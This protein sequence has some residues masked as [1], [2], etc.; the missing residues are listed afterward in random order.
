MPTRPT[1]APR[2]QTL[3]VVVILL[4]VLTALALGMVK[5]SS[6]ESD[7]VAAKRRHDKAVNC[8]DGA[9]EMLLSQFSV[10]G[11]SPTQVVLNRQVDDQVYASGHYDNFAVTSVVAVSGTQTGLAGVTDIS[12]RT[13]GS[14]PGGQVYRMTVICGSSD[15]ADGGTRESEVEFLIRFGL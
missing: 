7:A 10:F 2:G 12:N 1:P 14:N 9:R 8:A 4:L 15:G 6:T 5:R 3:P 13:S 11:Q